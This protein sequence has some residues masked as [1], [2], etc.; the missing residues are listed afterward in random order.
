MLMKSTIIAAAAVAT[1]M[2]TP[3]LAQRGTH[4]SY[5]WGAYAQGNAYRSGDFSSCRR[6]HSPN[7]AWDV[8]SSG[9]ATHK[10]SPYVGSDPDPRVRSQLQWDPSQGG[11]DR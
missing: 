1:I 8:C 9:A 10:G 4:R 5:G 2:A 3:A 11:G 6:A 7:P